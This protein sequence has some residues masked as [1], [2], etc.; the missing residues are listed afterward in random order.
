M[1][2]D[3]KS[4]IKSTILN[5][6]TIQFNSLGL[7]EKEYLLKIFKKQIIEN[8]RNKLLKEVREAEIEY[9]KGNVKSGSVEDLMKDLE[10]D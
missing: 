3:V 6:L 9:K 2:T 8:R 5:D 10:N 7:E 4:N 1:Q